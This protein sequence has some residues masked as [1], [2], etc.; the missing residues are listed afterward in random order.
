LLI[1]VPAV[2]PLTDRLAEVL[3]AA[4]FAVRRVEVD[5]STGEPVASLVAD[6]LAKDGTKPV[7]LVLAQPQDR[8]EGVRLKERLREIYGL[9]HLVGESP[10][11]R[12]AVEKIP[13][14]AKWDVGVL[15]CGETGTGKDL[16]SRAIHYLSPRAGHP[17]VPVN[18]GALPVE[19][20]ENELFGHERA[21]FTGAATSAPGL[22]QEAEGGT[23]FLDEVDALSPAAQVKLLRFLQ[24][25]EYR[26]LGS[27]RTR[28]A[29]VR[30]LAATNADPEKAVEEGRLRRDLYYRLNVVRLELPPLRH[31]R[32]DVPLLARHTL[33]RL[34][35]QFGL[36]FS[37]FTP[38]A[39]QA[40]SLYDWPG[41]VRELAH[42]IER[43]VVLCGAGCERLGCEHLLLSRSPSGKPAETFREAKAR[44]IAEFERNYVRTLLTTHGGNITRAARAAGKDRKSFWDLIRTH[45]I[46]V[47]SC[48]G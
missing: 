38:E 13:V 42:V 14:V 31:R 33:A 20:M 9:R 8:P 15:I 19:L 41:N 32:E 12:A 16:F 11:F 2:A 39:L 34:N 21:A 35:R 48:R 46:D 44:T 45:R 28:Q 24:E 17:F 5:G 18:C 6:A 43:A 27:P 25:K 30:V 36:S 47:E 37:G 40:L 4:S 3:T 23:L 7:T 10:L 1:S 29:D 22:V 26:P